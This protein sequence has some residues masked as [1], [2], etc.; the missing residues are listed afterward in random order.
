MTGV[1]H[2]SK[3]DLEIQLFDKEVKVT[4][5]HFC[6]L[7]DAGFYDGAQ[8]FKYIP[9]V[10]IQTGCPNNNGTGDAG[11]HIKCELDTGVRAEH[12]AL[13]MAHAGRN[14]NSSQFYICLSDKVA[15]QYDSNN[16]CFGMVKYESRDVLKKIREEDHID[17]VTINYF[18]EEGM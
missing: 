5:T 2:T 16:T 15:R 4:V 9:N 13:M 18:E 7:V 1:I 17:G 10:L 3:G 6:N 12:G 11:F 14:E 8:F